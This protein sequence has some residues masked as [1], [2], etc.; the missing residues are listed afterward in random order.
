MTRTANIVA[1][2]VVAANPATAFEIF[3]AEVDAWWRRGPMFRPAAGGAGVLRFEPG[4]GGRL[5]EMYD[6]GSS[7]EFGRIRVWEP[8]RRLVFDLF[9]RAFRPGESTEV[10]VLFEAE[11]DHTRVTVTNRGWERFAV[12]HPVRHGMGEPA[13][14]DMMSVWWADLLVAIQSHL[15]TASARQTP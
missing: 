5:L 7:Y 14:S 6:D 9:A 8:D 3:T 13:F 1:T 15:R 12:D 11:G 2:T 10:E 4:V